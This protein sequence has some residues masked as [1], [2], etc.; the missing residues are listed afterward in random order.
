MANQAHYDCPFGILTVGYDQDGIRQIRINAPD[1][2]SHTPSPLSDL[3][4]AELGEYF[5][6]SRKSF[7]FPAAPEGT[8]FQKAVWA[9]LARIPYGEFRTY[10]QIAAA[11]GKPKAARAVG[12][13][14]NRNPIWIAI[15]CHRV[16]G[17]SGTLTGYAG[18][19]ELK[20]KLLDLENQHK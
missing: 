17:K 5:D 16:V 10:G 8:D 7:T 15:P 11:I 14:A 1:R 3:A 2:L 6:G 18:G 12:Q 20:Q 9:E 13:A 4:A 19:L